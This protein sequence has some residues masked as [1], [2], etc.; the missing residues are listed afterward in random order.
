MNKIIALLGGLALVG[1]VQAA[2]LSILDN[3]DAQMMNAEEMAATQG[4]Y[5]CAQ[6]NWLTQ[7]TAIGQSAGNAN[8]GWY[9][10]VDTYQV[11]SG[12]NSAYQENYN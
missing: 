8:I 1:S 6:H 7:F 9:N 11:V 10:Y 3:M 4:T 12:G 2:E 5:C